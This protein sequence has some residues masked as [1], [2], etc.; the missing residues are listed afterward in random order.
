MCSLCYVS[1]GR[2]GLS[3]SSSSRYHILII[4]N[5]VFCCTA[6]LSWLLC[7]CVSLAVLVQRVFQLLVVTISRV[8]HV[9]LDTSVTNATCKYFVLS[10]NHHSIIVI[11]SP[12]FSLL[13]LFHSV[14]MNYIKFILQCS[15]AHRKTH[16]E[17]DS[18]K[19]DRQLLIVRCVLCCDF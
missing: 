18:I 12:G 1:G 4:A 5:S 13:K 19:V 15:A 8:M 11:L 17:H 9:F 6:S 16:Q 2:K 14:C 7:F 3:I 10:D